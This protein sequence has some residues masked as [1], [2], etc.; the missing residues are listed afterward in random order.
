MTSCNLFKWAD[1]IGFLLSIAQLWYWTASRILRSTMLDRR[2]YKYFKNTT[3][4]NCWND[5]QKWLSEM[6]SSLHNQICL[7]LNRW[8][9]TG[10]QHKTNKV[11]FQLEEAFY[12]SDDIFINVQNTKFVQILIQMKVL[13]IF[14]QRAWSGQDSD[15]S[16]NGR[17]WN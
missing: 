8:G 7:Y 15:D 6:T 12:H 1:F 3:S 16:E 2:D 14:I 4:N 13:T 11:E 9:R 10:G 5:F 17:P